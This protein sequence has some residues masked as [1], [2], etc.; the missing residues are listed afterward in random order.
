MTIAYQA[1][2]PVLQSDG[3][4]FLEYL[5]ED[6]G[7]IPFHAVE[8]DVEEV[9]RILYESAIQGQ[10]GTVA[11]IVSKTKEQQEAEIAE[12]RWKEETRGITIGGVS[13]N[14]ERDSQNLVNGAV[15]SS[16]LDPSYVCNWKT[17]TGWVQLDADT[18]RAVGLAVRAHVQACFDREGVLVAAVMNNTYTE[19]M[20]DT[21]WPA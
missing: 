12:R 5:H 15:V 2:N 9:G 6:F 19:S 14:T 4:I 8:N 7:W 1:R 13:I 11:G 20:L 3:G 21:G 10:Y 17:P 16:M 18:L